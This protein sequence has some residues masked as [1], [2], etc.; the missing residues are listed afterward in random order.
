M[1]TIDDAVFDDLQNVAGVRD[2]TIQELLRA[3]VTR[4]WIDQAKTEKPCDS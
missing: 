4:D 3:I 2:I 1:V